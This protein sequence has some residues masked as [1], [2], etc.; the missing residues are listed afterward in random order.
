MEESIKISK[1]VSAKSVEEM[2]QFEA[3]VDWME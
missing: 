2:L 1:K 3:F